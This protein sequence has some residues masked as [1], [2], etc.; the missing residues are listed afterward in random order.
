MKANF[1]V[2]FG[3]GQWEKCQVSLKYNTYPEDKW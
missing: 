2:R 3:G 1:H